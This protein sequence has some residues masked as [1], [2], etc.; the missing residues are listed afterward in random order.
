MPNI[1]GRYPP[2]NFHCWA[3][4]SRM[5][6]FPSD[7]CRR[8]YGL[9]IVHHVPHPEK[10]K[11][12]SHNI[13]CYVGIVC[14]AAKTKAFS[15]DLVTT[16]WSLG[17][18]KAHCFVFY[19]LSHNPSLH[20]PNCFKDQKNTLFNAHLPFYLTFLSTWDAVFRLL[21]GYLLIYCFPCNLVVHWLMIV[22]FLW[23]NARQ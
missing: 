23:V 21:G 4:F 16:I 6:P 7:G 17:N 19:L 2:T 18:E 12:S 9:K 3:E 11:L 5:I 1:K 22:P 20:D 15:F 13:L 10:L 8:F 14:L